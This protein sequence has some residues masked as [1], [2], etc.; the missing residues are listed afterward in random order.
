MAEATLDYLINRSKGQ[1]TGVHALLVDKALQLVNKAYNQGVRIAVT[2]GYRSNE[3]QAEKYGE[4]RKSYIYKGKE[5]GNPRKAVVSN[6]KPGSSFHNFGLA[7]DV[8]VF[9]INKNPVW[10]DYAAYAKVGKIGQSIGLTW[11]ADW[12]GDGDVKDEKFTD[13]PHFQYTFGLSLKQLNAGAKPPKYIPESVNKSPQEV[14]E[15]PSKPAAAKP[16]PA[17][18]ATPA[19]GGKLIKVGAKGKDVERIQRAVK[20]EPDG[21]FGEA[22][23]AAVRKYQ[24]NHGLQADGIVG[25]TTWEVMF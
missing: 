16:A 20:V 10:N 14:V 23:E 22:T 24:R 8:T 1:L 18:A 2:S 13:L 15:S 25:K 11:G 5:Y 12:D 7:F 21:K 6:A 3:E 4:G 9:D 19:Y 17:G